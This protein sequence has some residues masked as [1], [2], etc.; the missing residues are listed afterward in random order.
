MH[1]GSTI[2]QQTRA[3]K[4]SILNPKKAVEICLNGLYLL[5]RQGSFSRYNRERI[6][7]RATP[8]VNLGGGNRDWRCAQVIWPDAAANQRCALILPGVRMGTFHN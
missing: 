2:Y 7:W 4:S 5:W 6:G 1:S 3:R 8:A